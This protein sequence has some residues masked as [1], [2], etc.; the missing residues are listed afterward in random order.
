MISFTALKK[1]TIIEVIQLDKRIFVEF[2]RQ[3]E[4]V[5]WRAY[6]K[7]LSNGPNSYGPL[8]KQNKNV[9]KYTAQNISAFAFFFDI[10]SSPYERL[11]DELREPFEHLILNA[12]E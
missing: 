8:G 12:V 5:N 4:M 9:S 6:G 10:K 11:V 7:L 1:C 2:S 3:L